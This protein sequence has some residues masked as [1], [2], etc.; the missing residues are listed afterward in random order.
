MKPK[1]NR[2]L[3]AAIEEGIDSGYARAFKHTDTPNELTI[4]ESI[5][6][7]IWN[8]IYEVFDFSEEFE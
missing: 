2:I 6:N 1:T 5:D 4:K 7:E 3:K 8:N